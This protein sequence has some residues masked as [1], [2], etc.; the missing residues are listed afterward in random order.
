MA[1][2]SEH[3]ETSKCRQG[4]FSLALVTCALFLPQIRDCGKALVLNATPDFIFAILCDFA[5][6]REIA[7]V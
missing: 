3:F 4:D 1:P 5:T 6:L 7:L 2:R